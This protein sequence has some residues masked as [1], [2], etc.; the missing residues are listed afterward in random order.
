[1]HFGRA[2][3]GRL[4]AGRRKSTPP[5]RGRNQSCRKGEGLAAKYNTGNRRQVHRLGPGQGTPR[6]MSPRK[7]NTDS[8]VEDA[9]GGPV[10]ITVDISGEPRKILEKPAESTRPT[11]EAPKC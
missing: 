9:G 3:E 1:M 5:P 10:V 7:L 4:G 6:Q 8:K 2:K 11:A